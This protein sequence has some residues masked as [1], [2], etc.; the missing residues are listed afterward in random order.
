[1]TLITVVDVGSDEYKVLTMHY[2]EFCAFLN[3]VKKPVDIKIPSDGVIIV[4]RSSR[5]VVSSQN[6]VRIPKDWRVVIL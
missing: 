6:I 3:G 4:D 2:S 5:T 1:M